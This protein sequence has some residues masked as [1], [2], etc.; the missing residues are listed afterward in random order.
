M[1]DVDDMFTPQGFATAL[2]L[3][4]EVSVSVSSTTW[5]E[6]T[7]GI[8]DLSCAECGETI[9]VPDTR[10]AFFLAVN[11]TLNDGLCRRC[12]PP[13]VPFDTDF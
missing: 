3:G 1:A 13:D 6:V 2:S 11:K 10:P 5:P 9:A 7:V 8:D 12:D 4:V